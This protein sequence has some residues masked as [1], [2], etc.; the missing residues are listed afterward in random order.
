MSYQ[1]ALPITCRD[2]ALTIIERATVLRLSEPRVEVKLVSAS[3]IL[4]FLALI[5]ELTSR[6][7]GGGLENDLA[8]G[9]NPWHAL[10]QC[11]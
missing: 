5:V 2:D 6:S 9:L 4:C 8:A 11:V 3:P 7:V 10:K 1:G